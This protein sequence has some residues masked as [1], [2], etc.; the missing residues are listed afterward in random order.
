MG[1]DNQTWINPPDSFY[2]T[3]STPVQQQQS[4]VREVPPGAGTTL[5]TRHG[6][7]AKKEQAPMANTILDVD[8][9]PIQLSTLNTGA[10]ELNQQWGVN[11]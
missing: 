1:A 2:D 8:G 10:R 3:P 9:N 6:R 4:M 7:A 11:S 5:V